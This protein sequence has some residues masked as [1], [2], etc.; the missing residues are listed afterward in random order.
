[1]VLAKD[2]KMQKINYNDYVKT[3]KEKYFLAP[4]ILGRKRSARRRK[5]NSEEREALMFLDYKRYQK[6]IKNGDLT[7]SGPRKYIL[8]LERP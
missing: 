4:A 2:T 1:M 5:R 8:N 7:E 6:W 3:K